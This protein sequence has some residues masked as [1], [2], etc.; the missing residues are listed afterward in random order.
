MTTTRKKK[1][2]NA[3][4]MQNAVIHLWLRRKRVMSGWTIRIL[5]GLEID[6]SRPTPLSDLTTDP[7][8]GRALWKVS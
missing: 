4:K 1:K 3:P 8:V 6:H 7:P 5:K 2:K